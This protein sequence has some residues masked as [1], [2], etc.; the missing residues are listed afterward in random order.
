M[1]V[2]KSL[3]EYPSEVPIIM[4]GGSPHIVAEPPRF[5]QKISERIIGTG[6]NLRSFDNS[7]VTLAKNKITVILSINIA[8]TEDIIINATKRGIGL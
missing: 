6:L 4:F 3:K 5:A 7:I 1:L 2:I 8:S